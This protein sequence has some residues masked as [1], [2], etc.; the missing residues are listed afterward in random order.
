VGLVGGR[1]IVNKCKFEI[2]K[3]HA[4]KCG[5]EAKKVQRCCSISW[6]PVPDGPEQRQRKR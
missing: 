4:T 1:K 6:S 3:K 2:K 5:K